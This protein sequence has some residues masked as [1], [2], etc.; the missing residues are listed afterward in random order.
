MMKITDQ[1]HALKIPFQIRD[2]S[3]LT[4]PRFVYVYVVRGEEICLIDSGVASSER[5]IVDHLRETGRRPEEISRLILTHGHPDHIGAAKAIKEISGC[6]V[7]SHSA[8]KDWIEDTDQQERDR[9]VPGFGDLVGGSVQI[10][11]ILQDGDVLD[12]GSG[13]KIEVLHTPGHSPGSISLWMPR[14]G[15]LFS[16]DAVPLDGAMPIYDDILASVRSI[17]SLKAIEGVKVLLSAW[18]EPR[19]GEDAYRVMDQSLSYLQR[20]HGAVIKSAEA[21]SSQDPMELCRRTIRELG[22]PEMMAN[23]LTARSFHSSLRI[24]KTRTWESL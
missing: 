21:S 22:L 18:D 9:P 6:S 23:P 7:A 3:G 20:I 16:A 1:I 17:Q 4:I 11:E 5:I 8:D 24:L 14:E 13:L 2:P 12:L 15:V 10:D 19:F